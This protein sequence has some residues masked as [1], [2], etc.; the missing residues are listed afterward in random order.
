MNRKTG[1]S[2]GGPLAGLIAIACVVTGGIVYSPPAR[3][4]AFTPS[5][6]EWATWPAYCRARYVVSAAGRESAFSLRVSTEEVEAYKSQYGGKVWHWLHHYCAGLA[7]ISRAKE[8]N[9]ERQKE[10]LLDEAIGQ[11][12]G[13]Y[14][15]VPR[16]DLFFSLA[17]TSIARAYREKGEPEEALAFIGESIDAHPDYSPAYSLASLVYRDAGNLDKARQVLLEGND[18][19]DGSSAEIHYF[20]GLIFLD[21][22]DV[23]AA[24]VHAK[25]AYNLG[26]PLPG[27]MSRL[28]R[29]GRQVEQD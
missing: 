24:E 26:Y 7:Y 10:R 1:K 20:L 5:E 9:S 14:R 17:A 16:G 11:M 19:C 15:R 4:L 29:L 22:G 2:L 27:L 25:L 3:A 28:N 18:A 8:A 21:L 23:D 6:T 13:Q 12:R